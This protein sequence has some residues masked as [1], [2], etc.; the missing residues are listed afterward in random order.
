[1]LKMGTGGPIS[2]RQG[3][4][5]LMLEKPHVAHNSGENEWYAPPEYIEA[6][7]AVMGGIDLDPTSSDRAKEIAGAMTN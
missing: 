4:K 7:R 1:M 5:A 3:L 6:A 2:L